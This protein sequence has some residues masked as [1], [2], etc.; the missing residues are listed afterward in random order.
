MGT[1]ILSHQEI[2]ANAFAFVVQGIFLPA[3]GAHTLQKP[4]QSLLSSPSLSM[5]NHYQSK[6][7]VFFTEKYTIDTP[8]FFHNYKTCSGRTYRGLDLKP[9]TE[10]LCRLCEREHFQ[11][12]HYEPSYHCLGAFE[13]NYIENPRDNMGQKV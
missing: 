12:C 5:L 8:M 10:H 4:S 6:V 9:V 3:L 13:H 1:D 11:S 7:N 2:T